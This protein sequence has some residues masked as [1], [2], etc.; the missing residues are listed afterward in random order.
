MRYV[1]LNDIKSIE[2]L[3]KVILSCDDEVLKQKFLQEVATSGSDELK[4][5]V[6]RIIEI[7]N[8]KQ[9]IKSIDNSN[10]KKLL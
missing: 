1:K 3:V 7:F 9:M 8:I 4:M 10:N 2:Q 5:L 6:F